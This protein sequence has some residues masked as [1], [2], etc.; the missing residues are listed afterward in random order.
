LAIAD[1][2]KLTLSQ[3]KL[4]LYEYRVP[5]LEAVI[6]HNQQL[7]TSFFAE[8]FRVSCGEIT[9]KSPGFIYRD[10]LVYRFMGKPTVR[11][12]GGSFHWAVRKALESECSAY[13]SVDE[14]FSY[15][16]SYEPFLDNTPM[17]ER[18]NEILSFD[19]RTERNY[20]AL[21]GEHEQ[22]VAEVTYQLTQ[23][24]DDSIVPILNKLVVAVHHLKAQ[25]SLSLSTKAR[26]RLQKRLDLEPEIDEFNS[27]TSAKDVLAILASMF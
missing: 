6:E 7:P 25:Q 22:I 13:P 3:S 5:V 2:L 9:S 10:F 14:W 15:R 19:S 4:A 23:A 27:P 12:K 21:K 17:L 24:L 1:Q 20:Q 18:Y 8:L 16:C 11:G 26:T